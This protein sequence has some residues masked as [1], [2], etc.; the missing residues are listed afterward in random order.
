[1]VGKNDFFGDEK[2]MNISIAMATYN[3][4][5]YIREQLDSIL[6]QT[7]SDFELIICDDGSTDSTVKIL[8]EYVAKDSRIKLFENEQNLGF[9]KNFEKAISFCSGEY[10]AL[11]DQDDIWTKDHLEKLFSIIENH[12]LACGNALMV[13]KN[14]KSLGRNLN[15]V[16]GLFSFNS[17]TVFYRLAFAGNPFQGSSMLLRSDFVKNCIPIPEKIKYHDVWFSWCACMEN[18]IAYTFDVINNYRQHGNNVSFLFHNKTKRSFCSALFSKIRII[19]SG[20]KTDLPYRF[21]EIAKKYGTEKESFAEFYQVIKKIKNK[22]ISIK[23]TKFL[24]NHYEHITTK[25]G[26]KG[27]LKKLIIISKWKEE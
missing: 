5:K 12:S 8:R 4:E 1:M 14:G 25:K 9:K 16:D 20:V 11:S 24:W 22:K 18:G 17:E 7:V 21:E 27:F 13:D 6:N 23:E 19:F 26:H 2:Y 10:I 3:G 15:E